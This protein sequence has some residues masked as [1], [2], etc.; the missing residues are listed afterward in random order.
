M[1]RR[2]WTSSGPSTR[3][4]DELRVSWPV[5][6][7]RRG[8][9]RVSPAR[10]EP[11]FVPELSVTDLAASRRFWCDLVGFT[12]KYERPEEGFAYLVQGQAH[13]MLDQ[14]GLGRTWATGRLETPWA[15]ASTSSSVFLP[16]SP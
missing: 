1:G 16:S 14:A 7:W 5:G 8:G 13:L 9:G 11:A 3:P 10:W 4:P 6:A 12:V 2:W 15:V